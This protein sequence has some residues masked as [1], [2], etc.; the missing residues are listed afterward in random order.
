MTDQ[1]Q[2][3]QTPEVET[4]D[5]HTALDM[6]DIS[7]MLEF[8]PFDDSGD[9]EDSPDNQ[10]PEQQVSA[11]SADATQASDDPATQESQETSPE[12]ELE[13]PPEVQALLDRNAA[14]EQQ[15]QQQQQQQAQVQ[16]QQASQQQQQANEDPLDAFVPPYQ[17][18]IPQQ[19]MQML[20]SEEPTDRMQG[21]QYLMQG[22]ARSVHRT[23]LEQT[24]G[25]MTAY[26]PSQLQQYTQQQEQI[27]TV[28]NDFYSTNTDLNVPELR[29]I[30]SQIAAQVMQ[31]QNAQG[32]TP[33]LRDAIAQ[34]VR[35]VLSYGQTSQQPTPA[36]TEQPPQLLDQGSRGPVQGK[37][38]QDDIIN[39]LFG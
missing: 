19:L 33:D 31:E 35:A 29:P 27:S 14:L 10:N 18:E 17:F 36:Q 24:Q 21:L 11:E 8:D 1:A 6:S 20:D 39:T 26:V 7:D 12:P 28:R 16:Q 23:M 2:E 3:E 5:S 38:V 34:R 13:I 32:W 30:V 4:P 9:D 22:L 15:L 37:T 25:M